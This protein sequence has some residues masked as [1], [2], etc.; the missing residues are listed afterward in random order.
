M[1]FIWHSNAICT[2]HRHQTYDENN[3]FEIVQAFSIRVPRICDMISFF[4]LSTVNF[5][6]SAMSVSASPSPFI[7]IILSLLFACTYK[8]RIIPWTNLITKRPPYGGRVVYECHSL[9]HTAHS[10]ATHFCLTM[11]FHK[12]HEYGN[13]SL[14]PHVL[15]HDRVCLLH[16]IL[17]ISFLAKHVHH[18]NTHRINTRIT[19]THLHT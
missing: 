14:P 13:I 4:E 12:E 19:H 7:L 16:I 18:T 9:R 3:F 17:C 10:V 5:V 6:I 11:A 1:D 2:Y 8:Q 15:C